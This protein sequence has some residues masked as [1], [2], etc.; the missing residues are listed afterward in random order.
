LAH[1]AASAAHVASSF[2]L[3]AVVVERSHPDERGDLFAC[4]VPELR[5]EGEERA[6]RDGPH[7]LDGPQSFLSRFEFRQ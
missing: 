4:D 6:A 1:V 7:A 5:H 3:T 2:A